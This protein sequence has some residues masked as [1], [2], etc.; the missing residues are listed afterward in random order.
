MEENAL[1][2]NKLLIKTR[3]GYEKIVSSRIKDIN[4]FITVNTA[5]L[6]F[7]GLVL[8]EAS[9]RDELEEL[10][11]RILKEIHEVERVFKPEACTRATLN[12]IAL[13]ASQLASNKIS[14]DETF[15]VR[16]NRRGRHNFTS[17]DVNVVVGDYVRKT[18]G[19]TVNLSN[20]DKTVWIEIVGDEAYIAVVEGVGYAKKMRPG[21]YPLYKLFWKLS[22][23]QMPYLG[24][25]NAVRTMG[26]R[27][28]REIQNFE[29]RELVIAPAG[30]VDAFQLSEF[31]KHVI[32]GIESRYEVQR[33]SYGRRV[34]KAK[35]L[36]EDIYSLVRS[37]RNEVII[38]FEPEGEP[39]SKLTS[40]LKQLILQPRSRVNLLFG[41]REGIPLGIYRFADLVVDIAPGI[42]LSTEYAASSALIAIGTLLHDYIGEVN[43]SSNIGS[44]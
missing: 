44:R 1:N 30:P 32:E 3:L 21:K 14:S 15:A 11:N 7:K 17:I 8:V 31:I 42:T 9:N 5:P 26:M 27:I 35:V 37:R 29:V 10:Y 24:P 23:V 28:G 19:A 12:D 13:V 41:S 43:E 34:Q 4:P 18:T 40:E 20:P 39:I 22:I 6:G 16:T 33:K 38:V 2:C 36:V 25:L